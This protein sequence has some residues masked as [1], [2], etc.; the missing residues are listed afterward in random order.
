MAT[1][2]LIREDELDELLTL[3]WMLNPDDSELQRDEELCEH[4]RDM[5]HDESLEIV[6]VEHDGRLVSSCVLSITK[7]LTRNARPFGVIENVVTHEE[8]RGNGFGTLCLEKATAIAESRDCYKIML[9]TGSEKEW[10]HE[11]YENC[12]FDRE[13][14]TGFVRNLRS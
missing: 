8:Y 7:N 2:R 12:G 5:L 13:E 10:K 1:D 9:L 14:K 4:W 6:V 3:Y 11:F